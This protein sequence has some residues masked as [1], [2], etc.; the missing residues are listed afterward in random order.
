MTDVNTGFD[1]I[2]TVQNRISRSRIFY[3]PKAK[4]FYYKLPDGKKK[5]VTNV[6]KYIPETALRNFI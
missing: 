2:A 4:K 3:M 6:E 5:L 1:H